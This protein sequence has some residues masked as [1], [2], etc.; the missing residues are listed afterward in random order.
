MYKVVFNHFLFVFSVL[1]AFSFAVKAE[2]P[3]V[4]TETRNEA[5]K[6]EQELVAEEKKFDVAGFIMHH[7]ADAHD[8]HIIGHFSISFVFFY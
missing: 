8:W 6:I 4:V 5:H 7:I 3:E 1:F 2:T